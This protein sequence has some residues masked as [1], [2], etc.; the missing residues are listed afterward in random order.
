MYTFIVNPNARSGL[1]H[2]VWNDIE[3]ILKERNV[4]YRVYFTRYQGHA[5]EIVR[6]LTSCRKKCTLIALGGDGTINEVING[7]ADF[8]KVT[9]GYIPIGSS[10]DFARGAGLSSDYR[11]ALEHILLPSE[12]TYINIGILE[13][14]DKKRRFAVSSGIGFDA[15]VCHEIAVSHAKTFL[16]RLGLG[17]LSYAYIAVRRI[18]TLSRKPGTLILDGK[19]KISFQKVYFAA[20]MNHKYEGGGFK[21][22][23]KASSKDDILDIIVV[24]DLS[25]LKILCLL[26]T[27]FKGWHTVFKGIYTYRCKTAD[28]YSEAPLPVHTDGEPVL[29]QKGVSFSLEPNRL[30]LIVS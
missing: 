12:Y 27:A 24:A 14:Q 21:F 22:C 6:K 19:Q 29:A 3:V 11:T 18:L 17:K 10:N 26:P 23:P 15:G 9:F 2:K 7:I 1:G 13:Y 16:N 20:A 4:N 30:R 25:K 28:F 8:S 5:C